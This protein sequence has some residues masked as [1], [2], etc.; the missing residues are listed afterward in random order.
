MELPEFVSE[1]IEVKFSER[2]GFPESITWRGKDYK[3]VEVERVR[4]FVDFR[5]P[6]WRRRHRDYFLL[7]VDTGETFE[8]YFHR[9]PGRQYWVLFKIYR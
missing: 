2:P 7:K 8:I 3:V 4:R 9:G 5:K 1:E 6:W